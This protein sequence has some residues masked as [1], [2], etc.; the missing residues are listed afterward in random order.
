MTHDPLEGFKWVKIRPKATL[1]RPLGGSQSDY[2]NMIPFVK[3]RSKAVSPY[4]ELNIMT[5]KIT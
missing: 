4:K 2:V 3:W 5:L 1:S